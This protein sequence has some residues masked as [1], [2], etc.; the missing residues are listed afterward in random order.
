VRQG[1][2]GSSGSAYL[3]VVDASGA[4]NANGYPITFGGGSTGPAIP[5]GLHLQE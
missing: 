5:T 1:S 2:F 3:Y 4:S